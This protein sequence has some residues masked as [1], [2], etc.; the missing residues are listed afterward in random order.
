MEHFGRYELVRKLAEGGMA[1]V[2]LARQRGVEGF[3][4]EVALKR[5]HPA[6]VGSEGFV[7]MF[8][9]EARLAARL[10]HPNVVQILDLGEHQGSYFIAMELI[11]GLDVGQLLKRAL[12][13]GRPLPLELC[14]RIASDAARG[15]AA[16]HRATFDDGQPLRLVHRDVSPQNL[17][18]SR[19]GVVKVTDF[20]IA[21]AARR[22]QQTMQGVI[23]GKVSYMS[24]EQ[25]LG[26]PLDGRSDLFSLGVVLYELLARRRLFRRD[27]DAETLKA[28]VVEELPPPSS[29]NPEVPKAL[30]RLVLRALAREPGERFET[31]DA[32]SAALEDF[33]LETRAAATTLHLKAFLA[34]LDGPANGL[35]EAPAPAPARRSVSGAKASR[36]VVLAAGASL[37]AVLGLGAGSALH[38]TKTAPGPA[39]LPA[40]RPTRAEVRIATE[41]SGA[42]LE[43]EGQR[44]DCETPCT[45]PPLPAGPHHLL[46]TRAGYRPFDTTLDVPESG[47]GTIPFVLR[48]E[49]EPE[50]K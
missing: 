47:Q 24:P 20:G 5:L 7:A 39:P 28:I 1:E 38:E 44:L 41:P 19:E 49:T 29:L 11:D 34:A 50:G 33:L 37:V 9:D 3:T 14:C 27:S 15:L 36:A 42:T 26:E 18:V 40:S 48:R 35:G 6:L 12:A 32:F 21:K 2:H 45:L 46:I 16:A 13:K 8:L 31:G 4:K 30:D 25:A 43:L 17:L 22:A 10:N 23:R